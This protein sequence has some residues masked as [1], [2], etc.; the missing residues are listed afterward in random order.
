VLLLLLLLLL[1]SRRLLLLMMLLLLR[2]RRRLLLLWWWWRQ[3][4]LNKIGTRRI[5]MRKLWRSHHLM[6]SG[7][8]M[9]RSLILILM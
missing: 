2:L 9:G 4:R 1:L 6:L 7:I 8:D 3:L 5:W